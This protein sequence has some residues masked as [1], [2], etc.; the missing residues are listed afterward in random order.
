[1]E[2]YNNPEPPG[3]SRNPL[4]GMGK[5][6]MLHVIIPVIYVGTLIV[7]FIITHV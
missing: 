7:V 6:L 4:K 5:K 2:I 3:N 1:M